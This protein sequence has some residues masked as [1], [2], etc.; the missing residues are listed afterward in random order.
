M[1]GMNAAPLPLLN[2]PE[3]LSLPCPSGASARAFLQ[4]NPEIRALL[5]F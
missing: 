4:N 2:N 3:I 1:Y 5:G